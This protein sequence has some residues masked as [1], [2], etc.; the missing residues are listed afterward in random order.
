MASSSRRRVY[1][2]S[3]S[4]FA[5]AREAKNN[6]NCTEKFCANIYD[7]L[8]GIPKAIELGNCGV[9]CINLC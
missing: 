2:P 7:A 4:K 1:L 6:T 8:C 3:N 5:A 9:N